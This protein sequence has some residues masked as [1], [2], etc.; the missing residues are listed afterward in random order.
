M[1]RKQKFGLCILDVMLPVKDGFTVS[2][3][4][5]SINSDVPIIFLTARSMHEDKI[6]VP[7][8]QPWLLRSRL[9]CQ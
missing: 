9:H 4:I 6:V 2:K 7:M 5:R 3:E 1:F 8:C